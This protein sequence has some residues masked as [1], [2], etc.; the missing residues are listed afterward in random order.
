[1]SGFVVVQTKSEL[2]HNGIV[3]SMEGNVSL[4]LSAKS[5]GTFEAFYNSIKVN[6]NLPPST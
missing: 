6:E 3:L 4:Q 5:V 2:G 1:M